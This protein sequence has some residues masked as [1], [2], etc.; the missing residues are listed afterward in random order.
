MSLRVH[1]SRCTVAVAV[2]LTDVAG[3]DVGLA[4]AGQQE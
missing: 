3:G 2:A 4:E 1:V